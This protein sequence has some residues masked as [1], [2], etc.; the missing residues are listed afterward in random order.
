MKTNIKILQN[1]FYFRLLF[2]CCR[3]VGCVGL[4]QIHFPQNPRRLNSDWNRTKSSEVVSSIID[5][6]PSPFIQNSFTK[7]AKFNMYIR[8]RRSLF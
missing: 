7:G 4:Y 2:C 1:A 6:K 8:D 3:V 5:D